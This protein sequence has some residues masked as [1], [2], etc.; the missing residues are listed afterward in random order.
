MPLTGVPA[1]ELVGGSASLG[2]NPVL[3]DVDFALAEGEFVVLLGPNGSGKTTLVRALLGLVEM[4]KG[5]ARIFGD[6]VGEFRDWG[7]IGYVPQRFS[8]TT[9][10]PATV[11]EIVLTGRAGRARL[12]RPYNR[13]DRRAATAALE[14]VGLAD[15]AGRRASALSGGQGQRVL[16]ARALATDPDVLVLDEPLAGVDL[17]H[18]AG[19][20][21][22][23][24]ALHRGGRAVL[25][26]AHGLGPLE[27]L[28]TRT[29]VLSEGRV[30]HDGAPLPGDA[31]GV[32][33]HHHHGER[34]DHDA[35][36]PVARGPV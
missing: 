3:R 7:R 17:E 34:P 25:L 22:T 6:P 36:G 21:A 26:V 8:A 1:L 19:F 23:L 11:E 2:G 33:A 30:V 10:V 4:T 5:Q 24:G 31:E 29:V 20:A 12:F 18:Q 9:G 16:I 15:L 35:Y 13:S 14:S 27:E 28:V 32:H